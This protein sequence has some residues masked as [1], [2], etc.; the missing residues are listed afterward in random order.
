M[1]EITPHN[2]LL[3]LPLL[4]WRGIESPPYD[5]ANFRVKHNQSPRRF[6]YVDGA[7][8]DHTGR[9]EIPMSFRLHFINTL[10]PGAAVQLFPD[11]FE[12]WQEALLDGSSG[13]LRH[14]IRGPLRARVQDFEVDI[15]AKKS[16]AGGWITVNF[17]D[18]LDD[19][20]EQTQFQPLENNI[21]ALAEAADSA[22]EA[23]GIEFP[24]GVGEPLADLLQ[25]TEGFL[26]SSTLTI[27]GV[28]NQVKGQI[29]QVVDTLDAVDNAAN[30]A[31]RDVVTQLYGALLDAQDA[32]GAGTS[33]ATSEV[34]FSF[35]T[36]L[37]AVATEVDNTVEEL[38]GLN[39]GLL[40]SPSIPAGTAI[41]FYTE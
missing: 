17:T 41:K 22:L 15:D 27:G 13:D 23:T 19:P 31:A 26:F 8:H 24:E 9:D 6:P 18:T 11:L 30:L 28:I 14:P 34:T 10:A 33:R 20:A 5:L 37:T 40:R 1:A 36:T 12:Q 21:T 38:M 2:V 3:G 4:Q 25:Q 35:V 32:L 16:M 39:T 29:Q 7:G